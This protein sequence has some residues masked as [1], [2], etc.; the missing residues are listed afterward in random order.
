MFPSVIWTTHRPKVSSRRYRE[1]P[2]RGETSE[3]EDAKDTKQSAVKNDGAQRFVHGEPTGGITFTV[4]SD[5]CRNG[6]KH[7]P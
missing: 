2:R 6:C 5:R 1:A 3:E 4:A 7:D